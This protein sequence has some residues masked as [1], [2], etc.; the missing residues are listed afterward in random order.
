VTD[1]GYF[2]VDVYLP[3]KEIAVEYDGAQHF[4]GT[5]REQL[6]RFRGGEA[7]TKTALTELRD[8]LLAKTCEGGVITVPWFEWLDAE[9]RDE[10]LRDR[11]ANL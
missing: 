11:V 8:L 5:E 1:G 6:R 3:D 4:L 9:K 10:Y 2:S 7:C